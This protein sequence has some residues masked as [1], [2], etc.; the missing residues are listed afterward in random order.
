VAPNKLLVQTLE[1]FKE[2]RVPD[3]QKNSAYDRV[4]QICTHNIRK[5]I[6]DEFFSREFL[7][8]LDSLN[9]IFPGVAEGD[10]LVYGPSFEWC[11]D[12]AVVSETMETNSPNLFTVGDG[13]GLSQGIMYSASTGMIAAECI[14]E[15]MTRDEA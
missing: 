3:P 1:D 4:R 7:A 9:Q 5:T 15:R 11:M 2:S 8:F 13:A 6:E 10:N 14:V 12:T